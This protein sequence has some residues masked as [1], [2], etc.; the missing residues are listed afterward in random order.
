MFVETDIV[1][2]KMKQIATYLFLMLTLTGYAN[3]ADAMS[4]RCDFNTKFVCRETSCGM[5]EDNGVYALIDTEAKTYSR[6]DA[7][8]CDHYKPEIST[9][10]R[11]LNIALPANGMNMKLRTDDLS[12]VDVAT[13]GLDVLVSRGDCKPAM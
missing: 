6:C 13:I 3:T 9:S 10:G 11:F 1:N 7:R 2:W 5:S 12:V 4:L 8:G